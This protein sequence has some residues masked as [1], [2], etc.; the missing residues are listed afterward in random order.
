M[1]M[2][3]RKVAQ[4][5]EGSGIAVTTLEVLSL[6]AMAPVLGFINE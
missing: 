5:E 3:F 6:N 1:L 4:S 2:C